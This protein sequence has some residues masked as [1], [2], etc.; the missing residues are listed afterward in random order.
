M[1]S[2]LGM[3]DRPRS[4]GFRPAPCNWGTTGRCVARM[5]HVTIGGVMFGRVVGS[6]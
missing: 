5:V 6:L 4:R 3:A 2:L 1:G